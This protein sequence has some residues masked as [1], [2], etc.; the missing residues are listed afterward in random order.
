MPDKEPFTAYVGNLP[1]GIV[2]GD[3]NKV[4]PGLKIKNI[5][6]VKDKETDK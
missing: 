4:F 2:Q 3:L 5:R 1:D 6:L